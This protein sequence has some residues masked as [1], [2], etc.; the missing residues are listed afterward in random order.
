MRAQPITV[1]LRRSPVVANRPKNVPERPRPRY[2]GRDR[3]INRFSFFDL[4]A[5]ELS[6]GGA[7]P[8]ALPTLDF[9]DL[10]EV[11]CPTN[12]DCR[13]SCHQVRVVPHSEIV[14]QR[15]F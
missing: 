9:A 7:M 12:V 6:T 14:G 10:S 13:T 15:H 5:F 1:S 8:N 11:G 3:P 4:T 2:A